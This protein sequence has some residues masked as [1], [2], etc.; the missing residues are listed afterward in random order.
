MGTKRDMNAQKKISDFL[1]DKAGEKMYLSQIAKNSGASV[2]TCSQVL[3][4]LTGD[5]FALKDKYGNLSQFYLDL[6]NPLTRQRKVTR[7]VEL[8]QPLINDL[9][10]FSQKI[11]LFGSAAEGTDRAESDIDL[12][13]LTN[14]KSRAQKIISGAKLDKKIQAVIKNMLEFVEMKEKD[15]FFYEEIKKGTVLWEEKNEE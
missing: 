4:R 1:L 12:F 8:L 6:N 11:I 7:T 3:E 14:E 5:N 15:K 13:I 9:K 10:E 2:S